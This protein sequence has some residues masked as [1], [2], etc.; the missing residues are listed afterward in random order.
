[1]R[2][3]DWSSDVCSSDLDN[4]RRNAQHD[5]QQRK[6]GDHG[7]ESLLP[8]GTQIAKGDQALECR[9]HQPASLAK[10]DSSD[11]S[12][13]SPERRFFNSTTPVS[14]PFGPMKSCHGRPISSIS[15]NLM[16]ASS[17]RAS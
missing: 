15:A 7:N 8:P 3:S 13:R 12:S 11:T 6:P 5:A 2:I 4:E 9:K 14:S 17:G 1:M 10:A 16:P